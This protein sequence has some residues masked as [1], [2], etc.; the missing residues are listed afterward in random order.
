MIRSSGLLHQLMD[1]LVTVDLDPAPA[2]P[3]IFQYLGPGPIVG[4]VY[5]AAYCRAPGG[6]KQDVPL[7]EAGRFEK[8]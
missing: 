3:K 8:K 5:H 6:L 7:P 2:I 1:I 4:K